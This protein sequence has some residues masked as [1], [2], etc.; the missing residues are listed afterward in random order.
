MQSRKETRYGFI[1][2]P[3]ANCIPEKKTSFD[4]C[5]R[6]IDRLSCIFTPVYT[7]SMNDL[8]LAAHVSSSTNCIVLLHRTIAYFHF[9]RYHTHAHTSREKSKCFVLQ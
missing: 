9:K 3:H 5:Y 4:A 8:A 1:E 2:A 7:W 6:W